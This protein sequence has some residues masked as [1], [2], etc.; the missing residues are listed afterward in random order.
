[1]SEPFV[2]PA[3][4]WRRDW[5]ER[6]GD[7]PIPLAVTQGFVLTT[8]QSYELGYSREQ[9]RTLARRALWSIPRRGV[10]ALVHPGGDAKV[11][12]TLA[13]TAA[14]LVRSGATVSHESAAIL[15]GLPVLQRPRAPT[16]TITS[17]RSGTTNGAELHRASLP[18][19]Q[20]QSWHGCPVTSVARTVI[21]IARRDREAGLVVAD[22]A[23]NE[24]L[25]TVANCGPRPRSVSGG[26]AT[27]PWAG[28][29]CTRTERPNH[30]SSR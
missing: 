5:A 15:H 24:G 13:A 14:A 2:N 9:V 1:M 11:A 23:L 7:C 20:I 27:R 21:D 6:A 22:A 19:A 26:P 29:C 28:C 16:L 10:L 18:L 4:R 3:R 25:T 12:A 8:A 17:G 30:L